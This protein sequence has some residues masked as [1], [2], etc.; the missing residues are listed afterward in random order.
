[1]ISI[2]LMGGLGNQLFMICATIAYCIKNR[3]QFMF[4]FSEQLEDGIVRPTYWNSFLLHLKKYTSI[5]NPQYYNNILYNLPRYYE[6][7]Y[8]YK[9]IPTYMGDIMLYGY[10]QSYLYFQEYKTQIYGIIGISERLMRIR[11]EFPEFIREDCP[12]ISIHFRLGDYKEKQEFHP[13]LPI[14]YYEKA[15]KRV[16][17]NIL[18]CAKILYFCEEEDADTVSNMMDGLVKKFDLQNVVRVPATIPDW[19][20][21]LIMSFCQ[22]NIIANS[23]FSWWAGY[24]NDDVAGKQV[25][26]PSI[27][28][29]PAIPHDTS[30]LY[31]KDWIRVEI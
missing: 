14:E 12:T 9:E 8:P 28:F 29:G 2:Y 5:D 17:A 22:I 6:Q 25:Y 3:Q 31:P 24:I 18:N 20:Q 11:K 27:W 30:D 1:M 19:K 21:M 15:L 10:F 4:P 23:S 26:Y 13:I 7:G 16:P